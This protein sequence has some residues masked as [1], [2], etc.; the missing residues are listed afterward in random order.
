MD[1]E[2]W[3]YQVWVGNELVLETMDQAEALD[4][5]HQLPVGQVASKRRA[6]TRAIT[7]LEDGEQQ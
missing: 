2:E 6:L 4:T 1:K 5:Y 3:K 7:M